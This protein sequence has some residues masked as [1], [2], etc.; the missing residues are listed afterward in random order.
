MVASL[1]RLAVDTHL[2]QFNNPHSLSPQLRHF[3]VVDGRYGAA[4][5]DL[6]TP[7][8]AVGRH[9]PALWHSVPRWVLATGHRSAS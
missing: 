4:L 6:G 5:S 3:L 7:G 2:I 9:R 1:L 8:P